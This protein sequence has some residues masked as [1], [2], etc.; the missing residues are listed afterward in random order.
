[1]KSVLTTTPVCVF[2]D[3][4]II[5]KAGVV[6]NVVISHSIGEAFNEAGFGETTYIEVCVKCF[7]EKVLPWFKKQNCKI[8]TMPWDYSNRETTEKSAS[9]VKK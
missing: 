7:K 9:N 4:K 1:M 2:C 3:S 5:H 6:D 8:R